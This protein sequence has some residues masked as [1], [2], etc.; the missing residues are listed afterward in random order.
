MFKI[1]TTL[2]TLESAVLP[3][4]PRAALPLQRCYYFM[5][6]PV[7]LECCCLGPAKQEHLKSV[8][9]GETE[10]VG[11]LQLC[12]LACQLYPFIN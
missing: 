9:S 7:G 11:Y 4:V 12:Y 10:V 8:L 6:N 5:F 3:T 2:L 1:L